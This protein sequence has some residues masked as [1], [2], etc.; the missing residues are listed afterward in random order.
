MNPEEERFMQNQQVEIENLKAQVQTGQTNQMQ[1]GML[2]QEQDTNMVK[3][4][5]D[6]KE[7]LELLKHKLSGEVLVKQKDETYEW[8][9]PEDKDLVVLSKAGV[10]YC[11]WMISGY[12]TKNTLLSNFDDETINGK[13][14]D[15]STTIADALFMKYDKYFRYPTLEEIKDEIK[16]RIQKKVDIKKFA[17]ELLDQDYDEDEIKKQVQE[18]MENHIEKEI[19]N[20]KTQKIKDKLKMYES[21]LRLIQDSIHSTYNRAWKGMERTSIRKHYNVHENIGQP[22]SMMPRQNRGIL[23]W[24]RR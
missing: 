18:E 11:V 8:E 1:Q 13:M 19:D 15:I 2:M 3:E 14:E 12:L 17:K 22:A 16:D 4:Q 7:E 23:P 5:L 24:R 9:T 21:L 6:L 10:D 20:I